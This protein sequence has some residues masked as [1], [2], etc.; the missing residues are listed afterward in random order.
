MEL[1][2]RNHEPSWDRIVHICVH[3]DNKISEYINENSLYKIL[4]LN[5]GTI[6]ISEQETQ[7]IV[8][9]PSLILLSSNGLV[10]N[11][12]S[13]AEITVVYFRPTEIRDEFTIERIESGEFENYIGRTI[14]QDYLLVNSFGCK[15]LPLSL[16]SHSKLQKTITSMNN[17]LTQQFDGFWPCRSRSYLMELLYYIS[18]ACSSYSNDVANTTVSENTI[19]DVIQYLNEHIAD[20]ITLDDITRKFSFNRN[21][22]NELFLKETSMTCLNYLT[23][24]RINLAKV[25]LAETELQIAEISYRVGIADPNYFIKVFKKH[26]GVTPSTYRKSSK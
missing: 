22:L 3:E 16:S 11:S 20:K 14:Y 19:G 24:M 4:V 2:T 23:K 12:S 25:I 10:A 9:A 17:E 1:F 13:N 8:S 7:R 26:T 5:E 6:T 18:Y 15:I 21:K